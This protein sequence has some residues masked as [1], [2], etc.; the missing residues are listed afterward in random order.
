MNWSQQKYDCMPVAERESGRYLRTRPKSLVIRPRKPKRDYRLTNMMKEKSHPAAG[1]RRWKKWLIGWDVALAA[2]AGAI[3]FFFLNVASIGILG[4]AVLVVA[5]MF[6]VF[7][8]H[9]FVWGRWFARGVV[10]NG[11]RTSD[12]ARGLEASEAEPPD[13][14]RLT[15]NDRER[16]ELL[17]TLEQSLK[18][19]A[20]GREG[21]GDSVA[22]R[23]EVQDRISMFGA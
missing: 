13:E 7:L 15:L 3:I 10:R 22:I 19:S 18:E 9:F 16:L 6:A 23:R 20:E 4:S 21:D 1:Y 11:Q 2:L 14:F 8:A 5:F 17:K 12:Q